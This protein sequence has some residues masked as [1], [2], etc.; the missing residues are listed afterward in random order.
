MDSLIAATQ[1]VISGGNVAA[2]SMRK[3]VK[4]S[5]E[6]RDWAGGVGSGIA[7]T[8]V[9][10]PFDTIKVRVQMSTGGG[11]SAIGATRSLVQ[12]EGVRML[13]RGMLP[14][15]VTI[16]GIN[17][18]WFSVYG[19]CRTHLTGS[20]DPNAQLSL[21]HA[22]L[23][24]AAIGVSLVGITTPMEL[25]KCQ[26]QVNK[27][28][29]PPSSMELIRSIHKSHGLRG[30]FKGFAPNFVREV[31][32]NM[33]YLATYEVIRRAMIPEG[34]TVSDIGILGALVGG[35]IGGTM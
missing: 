22:A 32:G 6:V 35:A 5:R 27:S 24:G 18:I 28:S 10:Q 33:G 25:I 7:Q 16:A 29:S 19:F 3:P 21:P 11:V 13:W 14:P 4:I 23:T 1:S 17:S 8:L 12:N 30:L 26:L 15:L 20:T 34:G 31:G 2:A 9:G